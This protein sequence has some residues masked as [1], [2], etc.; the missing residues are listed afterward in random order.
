MT[1]RTRNLAFRPTDTIDLSSIDADS[2]HAA[3]GDL[4][5][6]TSRVGETTLPVRIDDRIK[7]GEAFATFHDARSALNNL[8]GAGRDADAHTPEYK[9]VRVH[10]EKF[11]SP[12]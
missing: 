4:V 7:P 12:L 3:N 9:V 1:G 11:Q 8:I 10:L 5:R 6:I 2:L